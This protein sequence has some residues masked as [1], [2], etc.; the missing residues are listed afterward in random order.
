MKNRKLIIGF[1]ILGIIVLAIL[2][3]NVLSSFRTEPPKM[4]PKEIKRYV[5]AQKVAYG[6]IESQVAG[7]GRLSSM[8]EVD[9]IAEVQGK[10]LGGEVPLKKGQSFKKG[11][12]LFRIYDQEAR[13]GLLARKSRFLNA[14][15]NLLP[16]FK[17]DFPDSY[18]K[19]ANF[20]GSINIE[21]DLP[22]LPKI[23]AANE[24]IFLAGRNILSDYYGI[25]G[26][27]VRLKKYKIYASF[28]GTYTDVFLEV[29]SIANPGSRIGEIIHTE[30]LELE[31]P[32]EVHN[33]DWIKFRDPVYVTTE[34]GSREWSGK[35]V[36]KA[37]FVDTRTQS[38]S[39]FVGLESTAENPLY[40][41]MYLKAVFPG[42]IVR[43]AMQMPRNAVFNTNEVFVVKDGRLAK[44]QI[45][46]YKVDEKHL[47]FSG[48]EE[49]MDLVVEPLVNATEDLK[50][51]ILGSK[52]ANGEKGTKQ[53]NSPGETI[54]EKS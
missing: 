22:P 51:E 46:I 20:L 32:I 15:A 13:F 41:G 36:R 37:D 5:K 30:Q 39:V 9:V 3:M 45:S 43:N 19:W 52:G 54:G 2:V 40:P 23:N 26:E 42:I 25:K 47:I 18:Q 11:D 27:E 16:D 33:A 29:G 34:D 31:V 4:P 14:I 1:S 38:I 49:G 21:Q 6:D 48:L 53:A 12:L 8:Q 50:V 28:T 44:E 35:V 7:S 10:I 17:V 24:K